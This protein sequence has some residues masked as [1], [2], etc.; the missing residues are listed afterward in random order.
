MAIAAQSVSLPTLMSAIEKLISFKTG[1]SISPGSTYIVEWYGEEEP[2]YKG[3]NFIYFRPD[4]FIPQVN[5]GAGRL[6]HNYL[7]SV[8]VNVCTRFV[9]DDAG[10]NRQ[11]SRDAVRGHYA[12][13]F[14]VIDAFQD[15]QI[16]SAYDPAYNDP[17][18]PLSTA[19]KLTV[20]TVQLQDSAGPIKPEASKSDPGW[21]VTRLKFT[22][23]LNL[24]LTL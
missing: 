13:V 15:Y 8:E 3:D 10:S 11:W 24:P 9:I 6:G 19:T 20:A 23:P 5:D 2:R 22:F 17:K 16:F 14:Q 1:L 21:G 12:F 4:G 18:H 7:L